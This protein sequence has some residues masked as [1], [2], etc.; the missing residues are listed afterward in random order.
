LEFEILEQFAQSEGIAFLAV[1]GSFHHGTQ[2]ESS[3]IDL[4]VDG[5]SKIPQD[6]IVEWSRK[7][8]E[9]TGRKIDMI[10]AN[11]LISSPLCGHVW[12]LGDYT[13]LW[14]K[15]VIQNPESL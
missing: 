7:L 12:R 10:P 11:Q 14:G 9:L 13:C 3:D 5:K 15:P 4:I 8:K 6:R 1:Y 2:N